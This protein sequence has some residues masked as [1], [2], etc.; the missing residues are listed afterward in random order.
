MYRKVFK[1]R[2]WLVIL[3]VLLTTVL[4]SK[5]NV[6][7]SFE[8]KVKTYSLESLLGYS[9][10]EWRCTESTSKCAKKEALITHN[11]NDIKLICAEIFNS[12]STLRRLFT[13]DY[14]ITLPLPGIDKEKIPR[15]SNKFEKTELYQ[16]CIAAGGGTLDNL[17]AR[18]TATGLVFKIYSDELGAVGATTV[19]TK[20][21]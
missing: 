18:V 3:L 19:L 20:K 21:E 9:S 12:K 10:L 8:K 15:K 4:L 17:V 11:S 16:Q 13:G 5:I 6:D 14:Y 2:V 7:I 1:H